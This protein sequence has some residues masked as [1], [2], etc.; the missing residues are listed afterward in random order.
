MCH[1][2]Y[3]MSWGQGAQYIIWEV[4]GSQRWITLYTTGRRMVHCR[5]SNNRP[6]LQHF[7]L[8]R[9]C[10]LQSG[11][12]PGRYGFLFLFLPP[13]PP[14]ESSS[15]GSRSRLESDFA[16]QSMSSASVK[17]K[18]H[19][20]WVTSCPAAENKQKKKNN[21]RLGWS[22]ET[23]HCAWLKLLYLKLVFHLKIFIFKKNNSSLV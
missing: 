2:Q 7:T 3:V 17:G 10:L 13:S 4:P 1:I 9:S 12:L 18:K 22:P 15:V 23:L 21:W 20:W 19:W 14:L 16:S 11:A 5:S 6:E 8:Q